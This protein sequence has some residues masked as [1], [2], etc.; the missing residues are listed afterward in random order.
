MAELD[1][2]H[3]GQL[4]KPELLEAS[5]YCAEHQPI[6]L[7][8]LRL[9]RLSANAFRVKLDAM[10]EFEDPTGV[11]HGPMPRSFEATIPFIGAY[12]VPEKLHTKP[13]STDHARRELGA[14]LQADDFY[15][16]VW[17]R[18]RFTFEPRPEAVKF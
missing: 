15:P 1:G 18:F 5:F 13:T 3:L 14:F 11:H 16:P 10:L 12:V 6:G 7:Q 4:T 9:S 2:C 17:D 8:E